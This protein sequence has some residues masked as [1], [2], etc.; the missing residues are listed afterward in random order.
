MHIRCRKIDS[1]FPNLGDCKGLPEIV[2]IPKVTFANGQ[3]Q[4]QMNFHK[5]KPEIAKQTQSQYEK[6]STK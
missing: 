3:T 5:S 6:N 4:T 2:G 1:F